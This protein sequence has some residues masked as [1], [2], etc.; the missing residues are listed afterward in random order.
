MTRAS[1][2]VKNSA[3]GEWKE[4]AKDQK[5]AN[6][7]SKKTFTFDEQEVF[8]VKFVA[9]QS[10]DG[11]VAVSEF[12]IANAPQKTYT[13]FV[14][15]EE[16]GKVE[17][18]KEVAAGE[19]VTVKATANEGYEFAGWYNSLGTKVSDEAEY[20]F[21]VTGNTALT[22]KFEKTETPPVDPVQKYKVTV[23][24]A[25]E[26]M[27][28][29]SGSGEFEKDETVTV[30]ATAK[31]GYEF[32]NWTV[33]GAE[34]STD[35]AYTFT[36]TGKVNLT[37]N[38]RKTEEQK[39]EKPSKDALKNALTE[40][41][42][43]NEKDYTADSWKE[44]ADALKNAQ[45]VYDNEDATKEEIADAV[46][47]LKDAQAQ[48]EKVQTEKPQKP[49]KPETPNNKPAN[50]PNTKPN[51]PVKTGDEAP[52]LPLTATVAGL[53]AAIALLFKKRK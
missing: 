39:P 45:A 51:K 16:G 4:V 36:V 14:Q 22:A 27:G 25:D 40:A 3:D 49:E 10:N 41:K 37:A 1:L 30:T 8:A 38:F 26:T 11:W 52:I 23:Q 31:D 19:N 50:K 5:F 47:A 24:S 18:G 17:G 21:K 33:D 13:V 2:Y 32:V 44:F 46:K 35:A 48:L 9:T 53:G 29:V 34:V 12:D 43:L 15:A 20:T 28:T 7:G 42:K 6:D